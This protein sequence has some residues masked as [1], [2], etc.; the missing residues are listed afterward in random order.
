M[1]DETFI[2]EMFAEDTRPPSRQ[3]PP[4]K[5]TQPDSIMSAEALQ[6]ALENIYDKWIGHVLDYDDG[7]KMA[8][9]LIMAYRDQVRNAALED[10]LSLPH[11]PVVTSTER[12]PRYGRQIDDDK[13]KALKTPSK[14]AV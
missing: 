8:T 13:I 4:V 10:V 11:I 5:M 6:T 3:L 7:S 2:D 9:H 1:V 12:G 14:E